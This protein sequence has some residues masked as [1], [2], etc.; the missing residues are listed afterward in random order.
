MKKAQ[1]T[2]TPSKLTTS[3]TTKGLRLKHRPLVVVVGSFAFRGGDSDGMSQLCL[4][5]SYE[6]RCKYTKRFRI[7]I[8]IEEKLSFFIQGGTCKVADE[9]TFS[10]GIK[11][12]CYLSSSN[13]SIKLSIAVFRG[14]ISLVII[15]ST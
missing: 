7:K 5:V 8:E 14:A 1:G 4:C 2:P 11:T 15:Q 3:S 9:S 13:F 12:S 6:T 10:L